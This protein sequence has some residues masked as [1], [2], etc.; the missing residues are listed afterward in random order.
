MYK[1]LID[2]LT[3]AHMALYKWHIQAYSNVKLGQNVY[4]S[5][6]ATVTTA[7]CYSTSHGKIV[8][9]NNSKIHEYANLHA[10]KGFIEIGENCSI[11]TSCILDGHG[12]IKIGNDVRIA[13]HTSI[14]AAQHNYNNPDL[15]IRKQGITA[16][17]I[18]IED[19]VWIGSGARILD[20]IH[21]G[22]GAVIGA[23]SVVTKNVPSNHVVAGVPAKH[24]KVR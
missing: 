1:A 4:V 9:G 10:G 12:G 13:N 15:E 5:S 18:T 24:L 17:G 3:K 11:N 16:K 21:I 7:K 14:I 8:I 22:K 20:G 6:K 19:D 23:G 2:I